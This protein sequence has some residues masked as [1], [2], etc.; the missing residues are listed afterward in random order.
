MKDTVE[1]LARESA[2]S[3]MGTRSMSASSKGATRSKGVD[4]ILEVWREALARIE[5]RAGSKTQTRAASVARKG[6]VPGRAVE[7]PY[8]PRDQRIAL[9]QSAMEEYLN[10]KKGQS[11][12]RGAPRKERTKGTRAAS[13]GKVSRTEE[14]ASLSSFYGSHRASG[15]TRAGGKTSAADLLKKFGELDPGWIEV[16]TEQ[17]KLLLKGKHPFIAHKVPRDFRFKMDNDTTVAIVGDW[18][19]G[20]EAAQAV[21]RQIAKLAPDHVIHLG[22]VYY[23]GTPT[24]V[25][26]RFLQYWPTPK[27][28]GRSFALNSN[29]EMYSG[30]YGYFDFTLKQF[31][32]PASYFNLANDNWRFIGLDTGYDE[33][34]L[35]APQAGWLAQ[36][37]ADK[38]PK[39]ILLSHHQLFSAYEK[40]DASKLRAKVQPFLGRTYGWIWGHE[41][42]AVVYEKHEGINAICLGN[43]CFPYNFPT[44][45]PSVKVKWMDKRP[46][47]D[48][49]YRGGHTFALLK[50]SGS[51]INIDF[52]D[53]NGSIGYSETWK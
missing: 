32:Q 5:Q 52:I 48:P 44:A 24:E 40:T 15:A 53:E 2:S 23:A 38:G 13:A 45:E 1:Q 27:T 25:R 50:I 7:A 39:T 22:D 19:G 26:E 17:A 47:T 16:V 9:F 41:H 46:S 12:A 21:A 35:H 43:G 3:A 6:T 51:R 11:P 49:D 30:G 29:H 33:H 20:N 34:D 14:T 18:G 36:Q 31:K 4:P 8:A 42:I 10:Q 37:L 28:P